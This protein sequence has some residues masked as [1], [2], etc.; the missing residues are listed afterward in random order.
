M[1]LKRSLVITLLVAAGLTPCHGASPELGLTTS[2]TTIPRLERPIELK[3]LVDL[4]SLRKM[5]KIERFVQAEPTNGL[6]TAHHTEAYLAHDGHRLIVFFVCSD[7]EHHLALSAKDA[8]GSSDR[9]EVV[10]DIMGEDQHSYLFAADPQGAQ[11]AGLF[12][13][14]KYQ[15]DL[16]QPWRSASKWTP[17]G[18]VLEI[19]IP[20]STFQP[21]F[22]NPDMLGILGI[23][24]RRW[25]GHSH[26]Y[27]HWPPDCGQKT[28]PSLE[29][30]R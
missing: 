4:K 29:G 5:K 20:L 9:L 3:D 30:A 24:L 1:S 2:V 15:R 23:R 22:T 10:I 11:E 7:P 18:Y 27:V 8:A 14:G 6:P 12:E 17:D 25:L 21:N 26:E 19:S 16:E 13:K 28:C